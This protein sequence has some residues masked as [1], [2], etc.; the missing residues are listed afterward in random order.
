MMAPHTTISLKDNSIQYNWREGG[1]SFQS[2]R[3][4]DS[5]WLCGWS[6]TYGI[7]YAQ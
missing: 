5:V 2:D 6:L 7:V 3:G 4:V 1:L